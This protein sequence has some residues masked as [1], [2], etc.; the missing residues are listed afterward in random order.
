MYSR[1][2]IDPYDSTITDTNRSI[3]GQDYLRDSTYS[4]YTA[5]TEDGR[6]KLEIK[7]NIKSIHAYKKHVNR[8]I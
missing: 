8:H 3:K 7:P 1:S 4:T 6:G 2:L 5:L